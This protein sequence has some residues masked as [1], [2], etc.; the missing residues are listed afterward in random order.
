MG[1]NLGECLN[2]NLKKIHFIG[3][4][5][6]ACIIRKYPVIYN[7][8]EEVFKISSISDIY[9]S[10]RLSDKSSVDCLIEEI[11]N[12]RL[13]GNLPKNVGERIKND[14]ASG[15]IK[16]FNLDCS[17]PILSNEFFSQIAEGDIVDI[18]TPN[19]FHLKL[20]K[21]ILEKTNACLIIEKPLSHSLNE[22][23]KFEEYLKEHNF[24]DRVIY[25][26]EHYSH[27]GNVREYF[28]DFSRYSL[29][30]ENSHNEGFQLGKIDNFNICIKENEGFDNERNRDIIDKNKSGGGIWLDTGVHTIAFLRNIGAEIDWDRKINAN[31]SKTDRIILDDKYG[32]NVMKIEFY[33]KENNYFN[34][35][36]KVKIEVGKDKTFEK[37]K[38][39]N[40][41]YERGRV[42]LNIV[43]KSTS[44]F[45]KNG[46]GELRVENKKFS[47]D[48]FYNVFS[49]LYACTIDNKKP[50]TSLD[51][52][53]LNSKDVFKIYQIADPLEYRLQ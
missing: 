28:R 30:K 26:A 41:N 19:K 34:K 12:K 4:L 23:L 14:L 8:L 29:G 22:I 1:H 24:E 43:E 7:S 35:D 10:E 31:P 39:F 2:K 49:D 16:Y 21:Q 9:P 33:I 15:D 52:A 38:L 3:G 6:D 11:K 20:A 45:R 5:G 42:E 36:C 32:E 13:K 37:N 48:P 27:Y 25:D 46:V 17:N 47:E 53:I 51:K 44:V 40:I 18:S 50:F